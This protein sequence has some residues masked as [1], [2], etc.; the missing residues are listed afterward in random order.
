MKL[1][2]LSLILMFFA[3]GFAII[4]CEQENP[5][6]EEV[7]SE[8]ESELTERAWEKEFYEHFSSS[9]L[10]E[11]N[12]TNRKDYNSSDCQ[13]KPSQ[14]DIVSIGGSKKAL[15]I[16]A[17]KQGDNDFESGHIKSKRKFKP[18]NNEELRFRAKIKF[19]ANDDGSTVSFHK[20]YG[21]WPAFWTVNESKWPTKGEIDV[22]EAYTYG[23]SSNDKYACNIF[24]GKNEGVND[25][26]NTDKEYTS[27][28]NATGW[29]TYE[30]RWKNED[31]N[32]EVVVYVNGKLK[33][34][35]KN[36]NTSNL[37][38]ENFKSHNIILNLNVGDTSFG[39]FDNDDVELFDSTEMLVDWVKVDRRDK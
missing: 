19:Q 7:L 28:V 30:M 27:D 29:N 25:L 11:W 31:G 2:K 17:V 38:L 10:S 14:V 3:I 18:S 32:H 24:Y 22:M 6:S 33:K 37:K 15:R 8:A 13:Y 20:T 4:S 34:R 35:Y 21:A 26:E 12:K 5:I 16:T 39:I 23:S 1:H 9:S 36:S